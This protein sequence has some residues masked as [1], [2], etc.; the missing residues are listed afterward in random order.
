MSQ[1]ETRP[2]RR[3]P[4]SALLH[5]MCGAAQKVGKKLAR[6]FGEVE[7][8]QFTRKGPA[9]FVSS[10][11]ERTERMLRDELAKARPGYGFLMEEGGSIPSADSCNTWIIDPIDGTT[12]F[13]H[14][15]P[16]FAISIALERDGE[17]E[18]GVIY[19]PAQDEMFWAERGQGAFLNG[20]RLRTAQRDDFSEC[21]FAT[22]IPFKGVRDHELFLKQMAAVMDV[23][24]GVRRF[25]SAALDLAYV[26][27]GRFD[28]YWETDIHPW[29]MAA[30]IVIAREAGCLVSDLKGGKKMLAEGGI[31]CAN[32]RLHGP[33]V[34]LVSRPG[35]ANS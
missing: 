22:G 31:V 34:E 19:N 10:A 9:D 35:A 12:N 5:V 7:H 32:N 20:R 17:L 33:L 6:D 15:L 16:H 4:R 26:A 8:L 18:A 1:T 23:S 3:Q 25:G 2:Q 30:G 24:A 11:D 13:M 28:G 21:I 27:A 14:G 29:D